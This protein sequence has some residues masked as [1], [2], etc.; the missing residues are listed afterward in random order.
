MQPRDQIFARMYGILTLLIIAPVIVGIQVVRLSV[1][2]GE[3]LR[4]VG[5][6]QAESYI[7]LPAMRGDIRDAAGR[8][9][10]V[11]I[12]RLDLALDPTVPGFDDRAGDFYRRLA[13][14]SGRSEAVIRRAVRT[15]NSP[16]YVRL[17]TDVDMGVED[18]RW[19]DDIPG[20]RL[21]QRF[22]RR[23][24]YGTTAAHVLGHVNRDLEGLSGL[25]LQYDHVL[26][27]VPGRRAAQ[28]DRQGVRKLIAGGAV[29]EPVHGESIRLTIDLVRQ[30]ILEEELARGVAE[31]GAN[32]GTAIAMD[33]RTGAILAISNV[34]TYDP[35]RPGSYATE[36]RRNHAV[37]DQIEPGSTFKLIS[38][39][40]AL[41][42]GAVS[43]QDSVET[44][45]GWMVQYGRTL[46]DTHP[47]GTITFADV[48]KVSSN[49]G[50]AMVAERIDKGQFYQYARNFGFGQMTYVDLPGEVDGTVKRPSVWSRPTQSAMSRGYEIESTPLQMLAAYAALANDGVLMRPYVVQERRDAT[51]DVVWQAEPEAVRRVFRP[52]TAELL[53]PAFESVV[54]DGTATSA[55]IDGLRI[56]GKTGTAMKTKN[57]R[58]AEGAYR[59]TF[60]GFFP[61]DDPRVAMIVIMDEPKSSIYGGSVAAPVFRRTAERWMPTMPGVAARRSAVLA[62]AA[63]INETDVPVQPASEDAPRRRKATDAQPV[64]LASLDPARVE[65]GRMP[66]LRGLGLRDAVRI[67]GTAGVSV[68]ADGHGRITAQWPAPGADLPSEVALTLR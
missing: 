37:T 6:D 63:E 32:W 26:A 62:A 14:V 31:S 50:T 17:A 18:R 60:V 28:K 1:F 21:E 64:R 65:D 11:N 68:K 38:A 35:N 8:A 13:S 47:H 4:V 41:E 45:P 23:Y 25:E 34:P 12:E 20:V 51:G 2:D 39:V 59:A 57:G 40:A 19:F 27:G 54:D 52:E 36:S 29:F 9:L 55:Q 49:V 16:Q 67:L 43:M 58:Y 15:R 46:K 48:I 56:A 30:T 33:P 10:A 61:V 66:D 24:N 42:S 7:E 22:S 44:G 5:Q 3:G 53:K